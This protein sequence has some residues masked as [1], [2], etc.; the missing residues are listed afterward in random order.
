MIRPMLPIPPLSPTR[1]RELKAL[2]HPLRPVVTVGQHGLT[3]AVIAETDRALAAHELIKVRVL[4]ELRDERQGMLEALCAAVGAAA[5]QHI[6]KT[7]VLWR[8]RPEPEAKP[9]ERPRRAAAPKVPGSRRSAADTPKRRGG[10]L[11]T[12]PAS[13]R[14]PAPRKT[15]RGGSSQGR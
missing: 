12:R 2:A 14:T 10:S 7:L 4:D 11:D 9:A 15:R 3:D 8:P 5:V 6:G 13:R 1:R